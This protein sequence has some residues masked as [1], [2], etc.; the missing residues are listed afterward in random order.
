M[1]A[2]LL[3]KPHYDALI[4]A[5]ITYG[6]LRFENADA[7]GVL[8]LRNNHR[9]LHERYGDPVPEVIDYQ[10]SGIE[11]PLDPAVILAAARSYVYQCAESDVLHRLAEAAIAPL[12]DT[13]RLAIVEV[14]G[15]ARGF[16][17]QFIGDAERGWCITDLCDAV[18]REEV[19]Q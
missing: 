3:P 4:Q 8:L 12:E 2:F 1:S 11:A 16:D 19:A 13:C 14:L 15:D 9:A 7:M 5:S 6:L 17:P 10:F 18:F